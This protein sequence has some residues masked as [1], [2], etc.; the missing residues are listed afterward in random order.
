MSSKKHHLHLTATWSGWVTLPAFDPVPLLAGCELTRRV[1]FPHLWEWGYHLTHLYGCCD[2]LGGSIDFRAW[3]VIPEWQTPG[4]SWNTLCL[5]ERGLWRF[6]RLIRKARNLD[7]L[8]EKKYRKAYTIWY[9]LNTKKIP[10]NIIKLDPGE[11][12]HC[13]KELKNWAGKDRC[14][15]YSC[16]V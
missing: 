5:L 6:S 16:P 3:P 9:F 13:R 11:F 12:P 4:K 15:S 14:A 10:L 7:N 2:M 1:H 8:S